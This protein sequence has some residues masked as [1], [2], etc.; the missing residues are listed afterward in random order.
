[1]T[2]LFADLWSQPVFWTQRWSQRKTNPKSEVTQCCCYIGLVRCPF[3]H[4]SDAS[5]TAPS[6]QALTITL[7]LSS[8]DIEDTLGHTLTSSFSVDT[9]LLCFLQGHANFLSSYHTLSIQFYL[10]LAELH[11]VVFTI[12]L[13]ILDLFLCIYTLTLTSSNVH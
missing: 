6:H 3:N 12:H 8:S 7:V 9:V 1:M 2:S 5:N 11:F 10:G 4:N 13:L